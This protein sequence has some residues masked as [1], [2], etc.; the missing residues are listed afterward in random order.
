MDKISV[1]VPVYNV[2]TYLE[3]AVYSIINQKYENLE[4]ILV[5]DGSTDGS[6]ELC[7]QLKEIDNRVVVYHKENGGLSSA[8]NC[9]ARK[10]TG[11]Y[12]I[13]IDSDDYIHSEMISSL[14]DEIKK[15]D[16]DVSVCGIMNVY[17]TKEIPQCNN[18]HMRFVYNQKEFLK[19]LL[20]GEKIPG[21]ICNK[22]LKKEVVEKISFPEGKIYEDAFYHLELVKV[23][24]TYVIT[25]KPYYYYYHRSNSITTQ[26]YNPR[27]FDIIEVYTKYKKYIDV[28]YPDLKE[29]AFF[30]LSY[31]YFVVLDSMLLVDNYK[32]LEHYQK[33]I[34][35]LKKNA[36]LIFKN[37]IFRKGRRI[38]ALALKIN[39]SLYRRLMLEDLKKNKGIN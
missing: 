26:K 36:F 24:K 30:R 35:F 34:R 15:A 5:D 2:R 28:E 20:I 18:T 29:E 4:I 17:N 25:T 8:R 33:V 3:K 9:G 38:A 6:G 23:A 13:F 11:N 22:L 7:D 19:E 32:E 21:S 12:V 16:A 27:K 31:G 37:P 39:V 14:Y 1:V 10:A